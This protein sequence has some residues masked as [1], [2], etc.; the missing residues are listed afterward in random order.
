MKAI[1][2]VLCFLVL[3]AY[4]IGASDVK[5]GLKERCYLE[6]KPGPC[7]ASIPKYYYDYDTLQC[8]KFIYGG[9]RGNANRFDTFEDCQKACK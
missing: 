5:G 8:R 6:P 2:A 4:S 3:V 7:K 1:I 9:C